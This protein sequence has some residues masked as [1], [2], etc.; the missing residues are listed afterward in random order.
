MTDLI[1][2]LPLWDMESAF[3][4]IIHKWIFMVFRHRKLPQG[5]INLF[6]GIYND[7]HAVFGHNGARWVLIWFLS[8]V[9]QGCPGSAFLF[10][11]AIDP[12]LRE[13]DRILREKRLELSK[14][15]PTT[16]AR[17]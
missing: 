3:P 7:A 1:P 14:P 9:L 4:S 2:I 12:F 8:G 13:I 5:Y 16:S 17:R 11:N 15:V 6:L 10:N